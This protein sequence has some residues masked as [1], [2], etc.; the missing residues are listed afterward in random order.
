MLGQSAE[1]LHL[2][3][4]MNQIGVSP[5]SY[6]FVAVLKACANEQ[7]LAFGMLVHAHVIE[8][9]FKIVDH[10]G[11]GLIGL[12]VCCNRLHDAQLVFDRQSKPNVVLW[13]ALIHGYY[14]N[15]YFVDALALFEKM[16][17]TGVEPSQ[18]TQV[19]VIKACA[20]SRAVTEGLWMHSFA[21]E[22]GDELQTFVGSSLVDMYGRFG[23]LHDA[24]NIF[25]KLRKQD[26]IEWSAMIA[27]EAQHA[28]VQEVLQRHEQM[29]QHGVESNQSTLTSI[30]KVCADT[31]TLKLGKQ[32]HAHVIGR[33]LTTDLFLT[34]VFVYLY[35]KCGDIKTAYKIFK[36]S[37]ERDAATWSVVIAG[38]AEHGHVP[39]AFQLYEQMIVEGRMPNAAIFLS[40]LS[41][42]SDIVDLNLMHSSIVEAGFELDA[43]VASNLISRYG[44]CTCLPESLRVFEHL[45]EL[46]VAN[47]NSLINA[48]ARHGLVEKA[49]F[50]FNCM[51]DKKTRPDYITYSIMISLSAQ[52]GLALEA[53]QLFQKMLLHDIQPDVKV[54]ACILD[55]CS[56]VETV[57]TGKLVHAQLVESGLE[58]DVQVG[59]ALISMYL[60]FGRVEDAEK[61]FDIIDFKHLGIWNPIIF[62]YV[63]SM[64]IV[65]ESSF[66]EKGVAITDACLVKVFQLYCAITQEGISPD[67]ITFV[68]ILKLCSKVVALGFCM[69]IYSHLV[70]EGLDQDLLIGNMLVLIF[71]KFFS[72]EDALH[73][74]IKLGKQNVASFNSLFTAFAQQNSVKPVLDGFHLMQQQG[75]KA[76]EISVLSLLSAC[77]HAGR[78]D[79]A[80]FHFKT[81]R[82]CHGIEPTFTHYICLA[83]LLGRTGHVKEGQDLLQTMPFQPNTVGITSILRHH[84]MHSCPYN[85]NSGMGNRPY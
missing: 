60:V 58:V 77:S 26:A 76:D 72:F 62:N 38:C 12:Y 22:A 64:H 36:M 3:S 46:D 56:K 30:L 2:Y 6:T 67:Q 11:S 61:I 34:N 48:F 17:C 20:S 51:Q 66:N 49:Y 18:V 37:K 85:A 25:E 63:Q 27:G 16:L 39:T 14:Q 29:Q 47:W 5:D 40:I 10:V 35:T 21:M 31:N 59:A 70:E 69:Q 33:G 13:S 4:K 57:Q 71:T 52:V 82:E 24:R 78:Q 74:F 84:K 55:V 9:G 1:A 41:A 19:C 68:Y 79:E 32:V 42:C 15:G 53:L 44:Q 45:Q 65:A 8:W 81:M 75:L 50:L 73:V 54:F 23:M 83:D 80:L 43:A 28:S 7:E